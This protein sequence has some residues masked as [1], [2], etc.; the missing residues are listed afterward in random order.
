MNGFRKM[1]PAE[2]IAVASLIL[3]A[4]SAVPASATALTSQ[5][6]S[7]DPNAAQVM[8]GTSYNMNDPAW[9][10]GG[11]Q[12]RNTF[13][14]KVFSGLLMLGYQTEM[15]YNYGLS[16]QHLRALHAFQTR[17]G[18]AVS[19]LVT[20]VGLAL[21]DAQLT[22]REQE[23]AAVAPEFPLYNHM[24]PLDAHAISRD[25]L[26]VI[27]G[28]PMAV[29]PEHLQMS[30]YEELQCI[31]GQCNGFIQDAN[32]ANL[33]SWPT[34]I[35][36]AS[37][38]YFVGA[39]FDP[40]KSNWRLPSAAL[41][42]DT[43]LHEYAHY[44]DGILPWAKDP[45][46][47]HIGSIDTT[48][49]HTISYDLS[50]GT[51]CYTMR[52]NNP[53]DWVT[54]YGFN[55]GY[56]GCAA[57]TSTVFE[58]WAEAFSMYVAAGRDF[59]AAALQ[60]AAIARKYDWLKNNVFDGLEYDTDLPRGIESGCNDIHGTAL[61][62]PAYAH[63]NDNYLWDFTLP[64]RR[65]NV[66]AT[67]IG[68]NGGIACDSPV[69]LRASS[70]C[71]ISPN[72][73]YHLATFTD[74]AAD[75][76]GSVAAHRYSIGS[77]TA[78]HAIG[79]SF[80]VDTFTVTPSAG[81]NGSMSPN[82]PQTLPYNAT[83]SFTVTAN[84]GY[85][86]A[87]LSGCGATYKSAS[88]KYDTA[89][90]TANC[91]VTAGFAIDTFAVNFASGPNGTLSGTTSQTVNYGGSAT[92]VTAVPAANSH[93]VNW[94][95]TGG[96]VTS[97][98]NPLTVANVTA[99]QTITANFA[100]NTYTVTPSVGVGSGHGTLS[101]LTAAIVA[102]NGTTSFTVS[103]G[104]G[105]TATITG[106]CGGSLS[107]ATYTTSPVTADCA[108]IAN[109]WPAI[110]Y[111]V[112]ITSAGSA[113]GSVSAGAMRCDS[114]CIVSYAAGTTV[115]F[116]ATPGPDASFRRWNGACAG[117]ALPTCSVLVAA[118]QSVSAVF[119]K[120]FA[121]PEIATGITSLK[122]RHI[123]DLRAAIVTLRSRLGLAAV[124]WTDAVLT[125]GVSLVRAVHLTELRA[126]IDE[127]YARA[128]RTPPTYTDGAIAGNV[129]MIQAQHVNDLRQAVRNLE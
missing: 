45:L 44:L 60:S 83:A 117:S 86:V 103:P 18:L 99:A 102:S 7:G 8:G 96:F 66:V 40:R 39:Y 67:V 64:V 80:A 37:A 128:G 127:A 122:A 119:S 109:F 70:T 33:S 120:I 42:V 57:G 84:S 15:G 114:T 58:E 41:H 59:R 17:N 51:Y 93:F 62:L 101:P 85:H 19:N 49:F 23:L 75:Q 20:S 111:A 76:M 47:P 97:A 88:G 78:D 69:D 10:V 43:V 110:N 72:P 4:L 116:T 53:K 106:T 94:T 126:A 65:Y 118:A 129:T 79:G 63:C 3:I 28:L 12:N 32:G 108:V 38:Y 25:T 21:M 73:G 52:S 30:A 92:A 91:T 1:I 113:D 89:A 61:A 68:G 36:P 71:T 124:P 87:S 27:Y 55:P 54:K 22:Q 48:G 5:F 9:L 112:T 29:L 24:E 35:N 107:G 77:V 121:D 105:Y 2:L 6:F 56:G 104:S 14:Y 46:L 81:A 90:V 125:P 82:T 115:T 16:D 95:G 98:T 100:I 50:S 26:A 11:N 74:D 13:A 31:A 34:P 123:D